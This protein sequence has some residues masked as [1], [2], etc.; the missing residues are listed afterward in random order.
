MARRRPTDVSQAPDNAEVSLSHA[1]SSR[2]KKKDID[3][4]TVFLSVFR[5]PLAALLICVPIAW[6][7]RF[8]GGGVAPIWNFVTNFFAIIPLSWLLSVAT[9][10]LE[11]KVGQAMGALLNSTFGNMVEIILSIQAIRAGMI[12]VVQSN[13]MGAIFMNLLFVLGCAFFVG[14]VSWKNSRFNRNNVSYCLALLAV[15]CLAL[16]VPTALAVFDEWSSQGE[17]LIV[18]RA[19]AGLLAVM[20]LQWLLFQMSTHKFMFMGVGDG[21]SGDNTPILRG[22]S[23]PN[24]PTERTGTASDGEQDVAPEAED[25]EPSLSISNASAL[26]LVSTVIVTFHCDWLVNA[27]HPLCNEFGVK[28]AFIATILLPI[29]GGFAEEISAITFAAKGKMDLAISIS[30]GSATQ[31]SLLVVPIAVFLGWGLG[32][33]F[34]LDFEAFQVQLMVMSLLVAALSLQDNRANW[35]KGSLLITSYVILAASFC[36]LHDREFHSAGARISIKELDKEVEQLNS[37]VEAF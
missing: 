4:G 31:I 26:L 23:E 32:V 27:I 20:Y 15:A 21:Y 22:D 2:S 14:G 37:T 18:S 30:I 24:T 3:Q 16:L 36:F 5:H 17:R 34:D 7:L 25:E 11:M 10:H 19:I 12:K 6:V 29:V 13:L 28:E 9:E 1:I 33:P 35:L 8:L